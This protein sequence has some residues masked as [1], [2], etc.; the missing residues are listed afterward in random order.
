MGAYIV[1]GISRQAKAN[2]FWVCG[3]YLHFGRSSKQSTGVDCRGFV[4]NVLVTDD[5]FPTFCG[6]KLTL[7][8]VP[9]PTLLSKVT[10]PSSASVIRLTTANPN[11]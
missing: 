3:R 5:Y 7:N 10:A 9:S 6:G 11:P 8:L 1:I 2:Y 4:L